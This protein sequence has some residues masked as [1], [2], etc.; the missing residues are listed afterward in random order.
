MHD[1]VIRNGRI[2]DGTGTPEF[3]GDNAIDGD[4]ISAV[5]REGEGI[6]GDGRREIDAS[7]KVV[8]PGWIDIH[9]HMDAQVS[10]DPLHDAVLLQRR[11][12]GGDGQLWGRL[13][14]GA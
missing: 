10:W 9:T 5:V 12:D 3:V 1:I 13:C 6:V 14:A 7:G 2:L 4:R 11:D 8:T